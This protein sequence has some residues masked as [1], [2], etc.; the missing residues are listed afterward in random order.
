MCDD[1][2]LIDGAEDVNLIDGADDGAEDV[3][4][5]DSADDDLS[6][7]VENRP[8]ALYQLSPS[9]GQCNRTMTGGQ[10]YRN[11]DKGRYLHHNLP[12]LWPAL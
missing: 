1:V 7:G 2:N 3:D 5:I 6:D 9:P 11:D 12:L 8:L 4:L 10:S